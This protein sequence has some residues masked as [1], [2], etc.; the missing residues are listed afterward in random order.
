MRILSFTK[1]GFDDYTHWQNEDRKTL[2]RI[3][4]L[5]E[6]IMRNGP[7]TG[8][9]KP[10]SLKKTPRLWSRRIDSKNRLFYS[11]DDRVVVIHACK[12]HYGDK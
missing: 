10:E 2:K 5:I 8:L 12:T 4:A 7:S 11:A 1:D 6:D 3:N 9:G